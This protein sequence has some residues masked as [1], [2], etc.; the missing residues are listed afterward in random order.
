MIPWGDP[1]VTDE[2][3]IADEMAQQETKNRQYEASINKQYEEHL[4]Q[5][6]LDSLEDENE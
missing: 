5:E 1:Y 2:D 4:E 3:M 6:Y